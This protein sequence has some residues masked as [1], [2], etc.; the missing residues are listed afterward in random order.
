MKIAQLKDE[1]DAVERTFKSVDESVS[2][3][4][5]ITV[6]VSERLEAASFAKERASR[7][8]LLLKYFDQ[9]NNTHEPELVFIL[10]CFIL[11]PNFFPLKVN[12]RLITI[13]YQKLN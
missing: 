2:E 10:L 12:K 3:Y 7:A 8:M 11:L 1:Y 5:R 9:L 6:N 4:V 13:I